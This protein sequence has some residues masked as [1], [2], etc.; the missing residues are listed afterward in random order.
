M[1]RSLAWRR[2]VQRRG[3]T[4]GYTLGRVGHV[5]HSVD[6][7]RVCDPECKDHF[8]LRIC[9]RDVCAVVLNCLVND[10]LR[11]VGLLFALDDT[12]LHVNVEVG[13]VSVLGSESVGLQKGSGGVGPVFLDGGKGSGSS[14]AVFGN[15][16]S[17][18]QLKTVLFGECFNNLVESGDE[19]IDR[20]A[21]GLL[22]AEESA[23]KG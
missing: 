11:N 10:F 8:C 14:E 18:E 6:V 7:P 9:R 4:R 1:N 23:T 3:R 16:H 21:G 13:A 22:K 20:H 5:G 15:D 2:L 12:H 19:C 17:V